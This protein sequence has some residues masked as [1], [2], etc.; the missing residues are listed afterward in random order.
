[1]SDLLTTPTPEPARSS[2]TLLMSTHGTCEVR[3]RRGFAATSICIY[4]IRDANGGRKVDQ[5]EDS[6][7]SFISSLGCTSLTSALVK[8]SYGLGFEGD[9]LHVTR[10]RR[11]NGYEHKYLHDYAY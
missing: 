5:R 7:A 4:G 2:V 8:L 1:M 11:A 10:R 9:A 6:I 3:E